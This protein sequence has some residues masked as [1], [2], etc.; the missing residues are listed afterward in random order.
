MRFFFPYINES[1]S[2]DECW[3]IATDQMN[4]YYSYLSSIQGVIPPS[5]YYVAEH[6]NFG[7]YRIEEISADFI[8]RSLS[9]KIIGQVI[10]SGVERYFHLNYREVSAFSIVNRSDKETSSCIYD[11]EISTDELELVDPQ[12][13]IFEHRFI[14][15]NRT[16]LVVRFQKFVYK[17]IDLVCESN[18]GTEVSVP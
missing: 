16:E 6:I 5:L 11:Y 17:E 15:V 10:V 3:R 13:L 14:F 18:Q 2:T 8:N 1:M 9:L 12:Q 4:Q 7:D